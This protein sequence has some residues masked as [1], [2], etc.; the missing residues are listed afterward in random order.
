MSRKIE[1]ERKTRQNTENK[2]TF[3]LTWKTILNFDRNTP[4]GSVDEETTL[5][6]TSTLDGVLIALPFRDKIPSGIL[7]DCRNFTVKPLEARTLAMTVLISL[8]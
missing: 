6:P 3:T 5:P 4:K 2:Q 1:I 7:D 8:M